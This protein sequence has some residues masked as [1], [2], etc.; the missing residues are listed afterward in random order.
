M[1]REFWRGKRVVV[2]GDTGFK[3]AWLALWLHALGARVLGYA[4]DVPTRPSLFEAAR[5]GELVEHRAGD[6][7]DFADV[8]RSIGE[9][10]PEVVFHLAAQSLVRYSYEQPLETYAT[11]VM[12]TA[13]VLEAV[14][15]ARSVRAVVVVTSDKCYENRETGRAY[16]ETDPLG[17]R[18][19]YSSSKGAAELVASAYSRSFFC[20]AESKVAV[21][22]ARAGNVIGG[23]DWSRDRLLP[24][25][26]RAAAAGTPVQIRNPGAV[27]PWQHVLEPLAGY[28]LLAQRLAEEGAR[29]AGAWNFGPPASDA[30]PVSEIMDR[31][32]SLWGPGLRWEIDRGAHPH[33]AKLLC[34][35]AARAR[36]LL[37]WTPRLD[38]DTAVDWTV[39]WYKAFLGGADARRLSEAQIERYQRMGNA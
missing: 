13:H 21:A 11:N 5:I 18:D 8:Q 27:R 34:L 20:A 23:G 39:A 14:R 6:V 16:V 33:E 10:R 12:G 38:L 28:L 29:I 25:A 24:D 26:Y 3:G 4:K 36:E 19:P 31:A 2:T 32:A 30:R 15:G 35:D 22:T 1:N 37:G 9:F 17:G 7:R